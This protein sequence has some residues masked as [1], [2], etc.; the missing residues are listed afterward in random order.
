MTVVK[1]TRIVTVKPDLGDRA[2]VVDLG[3]S[4]DLL[5]L[6]VAIKGVNW[7][8]NHCFRGFSH[9]DGKCIAQAENAQHQGRKNDKK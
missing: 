1:S 2:L 4:V 9:L 6:V 7:E 3:L 8:M 5:G